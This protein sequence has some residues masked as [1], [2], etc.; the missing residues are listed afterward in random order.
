[1]RALLQYV[2]LTV[3]CTCWPPLP[4]CVFGEKLTSRFP[5]KRSLRDF[6]RWFVELLDVARIWCFAGAKGFNFFVGAPYN[7]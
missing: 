3:E 5:K 7:E 4:V 1:M 2:L 6:N